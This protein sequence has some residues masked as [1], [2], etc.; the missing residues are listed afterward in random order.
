MTL[1]PLFGGELEAAPA[2][3]APQAAPPRQECM[4]DLLDTPQ[5]RAPTQAEREALVEKANKA[6]RK[7][8][9]LAREG[10][11]SLDEYAAVERQAGRAQWEAALGAF[12][13]GR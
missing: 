5:P 13:V 6:A 3:A 2:P 9:R 4:A 8:L 10:K 12:E 11:M 1:S 7:A